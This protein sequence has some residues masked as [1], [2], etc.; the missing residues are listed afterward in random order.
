MK[1]LSVALSL[2]TSC[3][4]SFH[5]ALNSKRTP[6]IIAIRIAFGLIAVENGPTQRH[7]LIVYELFF[8]YLANR[9]TKF[10]VNYQNV[11]KGVTFTV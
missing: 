2:S 4:V 1:S 3:S 9:C 8:D 6:I 11:C 7:K 10:K 5:P